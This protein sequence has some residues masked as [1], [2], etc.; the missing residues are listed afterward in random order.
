M[1]VFKHKLVSPLALISIDYGEHAESIILAVNANLEGWG[2]TLMIFLTMD[3]D[4][5]W[6][7]KGAFAQSSY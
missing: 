2:A 7:Q 4:K 6:L 3:K 1:S 5:V